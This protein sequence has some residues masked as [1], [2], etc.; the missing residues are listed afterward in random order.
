MVSIIYWSVLFPTENRFSDEAYYEVSVHLVA[1]LFLLVEFGLNRILLYPERW[2][3]LVAI[4]TVYQ[5]FAVAY[6]LIVG[7]EI[8]PFLSTQTVQCLPTAMEVGIA[9]LACHYCSCVL[10]YAKERYGMETTT[11]AF[12]TQLY[13]T[14]M[15]DY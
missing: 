2:T 5:Q 15:P 10:S 8:Y 6:D 9:G 14:L 3:W 7:S 12:Q 1:T 4:L 13:D 11:P